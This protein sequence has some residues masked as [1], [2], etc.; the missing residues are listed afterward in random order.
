MGFCL[1]NS[2]AVAA[3]HAQA[4]HG[5]GRVAIVDFDVHHGNGTQAVAERDPTLFFASSHQ[6][7]LYPGTGA[8]DETGVGNIVNVPLRPGTEGAHFRRA[9]EARIL[10]ALDAFAPE[11]LLV[12][13]GFDA[14]RADPLAGLELEEEDFGWVT[15]RLVEAAG[16]H[17]QGR[18]VSVLEGGYDLKALAA[19]AA[20][21]VSAL[22]NAG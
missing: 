8:A 4:A 17:A 19:S 5:I 16:R 11:L 12:S 2:I 18:L 14:H 22:M 10:P 15:T 21:H 6:Y 20:S 1:F 9:F 3:R 7:P 13:A